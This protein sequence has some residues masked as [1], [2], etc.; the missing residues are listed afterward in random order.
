MRAKLLLADDHSI[1]LEGMRSVIGREHDLVGEVRD[2]RA[3]VAEALRLRPDLIVLDIGMPLLNGIEATRQIRRAW[4]RAKLLFVSMHS[5][6]LYV[7]EAMNAGASGYILKTSAA[8]ELLPAI[9]AVL[10]GQVYMSPALGPNVIPAAPARRETP[11]LTER[12]REVLQLIAEGHSSKEVASILGISIKTANFHRYE[13]KKKLG[14][15]SIAELAAFA[16]RSGLV[17]E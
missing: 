15:H 3:L 4:P 2:G 8:E 13:V 16:A 5:N 9:R 14:V 6:G 1:T 12:Q 17:S 10:E 11:G 7:R